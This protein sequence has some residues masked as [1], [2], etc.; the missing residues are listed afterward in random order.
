MT[1]FSILHCSPFCPSEIEP[2]QSPINSAQIKML[3]PI[4]GAWRPESNVPTLDML[5]RRLGKIQL[6]YRV[7]A[8]Q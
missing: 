8:W 1:M 2:E 5:G 7:I 6:P 3:E 4:S